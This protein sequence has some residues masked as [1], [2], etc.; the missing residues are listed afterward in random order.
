MQGVVAGQHRVVVKDCRPIFGRPAPIAGD[1]KLAVVGWSRLA[2]LNR[3]VRCKL[4]RPCR[5]FAGVCRASA[6]DVKLISAFRC[7]VLSSKALK[8]QRWRRQCQPVA[9]R[10]AA[11]AHQQVRPGCRAQCSP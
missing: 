11:F 3:R 1:R 6:G 4:P 5:L 10:R 8:A 7:Y 9:H 2:R